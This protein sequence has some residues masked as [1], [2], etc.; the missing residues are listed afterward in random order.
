MKDPVLPDCPECTQTCDRA[1]LEQRSAT[2]KTSCPL[3]GH[4]H[5]RSN[6]I[7][8]SA[9]LR[10]TTDALQA[11]GILS[12][13][14]GADHSSPQTGS[15]PQNGFKTHTY[16]DGG[17]YVGEWKNGRQH[18]SGK[19]VYM[20]S[21]C[22]YDGEWVDDKRHGHGVYTWPHGETYVGEYQNDDRHG[23]GKYVFASGCIYDGDWVDDEMHGRG[24]HT[25]PDGGKYVGEWKNS[26]RHGSGKQVFASGNMNHDGDWEND[27]PKRRRWWWTS[28][29]VK[30]VDH[31]KHGHDVL[32]WPSGA[33]CV[34]EFQNNKRHC[35]GKQV[36]AGGNIYHD[37]DWGKE[38]PK[39]RRWWWPN[40][41]VKWVDDKSHGRGVYT[42]P[43]GGKDVGEWKD[44][45]RHGSG[46]MVYASGCIYDGDWVDDEMHGR[47][48][49]TWP[50]GGKY[51]GEWKNSKRNGSGKQ[52]FASGNMNHDGDWENDKPKRRRW[53]WTSR[54]VKGISMAA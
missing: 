22:I 52:V 12:G 24:V 2:E 54:Q 44:D 4:D 7:H 41:Q 47:G 43:D 20:P 45:K 50:D 48:V 9:A 30:W 8:P 32:T 25:W 36:C 42:W 53:W 49:H 3:G 5:L 27:K 37:G 39:R 26:K 40:R 28:R 51:V 29:Q 46:K 15:P 33:R 1:S 14:H 18:G 13:D 31:K 38:K 17:K 23:S 34:G 35:R 19:R 21:G 6:R 10:N 11:N 16:P